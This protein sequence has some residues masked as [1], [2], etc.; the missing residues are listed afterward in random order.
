MAPQ[1]VEEAQKARSYDFII[2]GG[3]TAGCVLASRLS[4]DPHTSVLVLEAGGNNNALEVKAPLVF[5]KNFRTERD[6]DYTTTPQPALLNKEFQWPRGKLIGG[7][8]S[9]NAMMY[10]HCAPSD[11]DEWSEKFNCKGWSYKELLPYLTRA[12]KYTP[13]A[14][15]P[16]VK[17]DERGNSG[18][19]QT[20]HS[21]Y[22]A[23]VT[24]K[25]FINACVEVGI[26]HSSDLNTPRGSEGCTQFTTF[27]DSKGQRS[28]AATAYL[29]LEVQRRPNLTIGINVMVNRIL[30]DRTGSRPKAIAVEMQNKKGGQKYYAAANQRLSSAAVPSTRLRHSCSLVLAQQPC[31]RSTTSLSSSRT[32]WWASVSA[33][34]FATLVSV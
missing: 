18:P 13:H 25:G 8:S 9:I 28:S 14:S 12:E 30:F 5:T 21:S 19:W 22:K 33:T 16:D 23:E 32:P 24:S 11:Y 29:P 34:T 17:A 6:W 31:S 1:T 2:C 27:I 3:G 20:G 15:Q 4:E 10:H 7:S 26:P